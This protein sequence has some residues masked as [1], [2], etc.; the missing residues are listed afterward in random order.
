MI[1]SEEEMSNDGD[2]PDNFSESSHDDSVSL[3]VSMTS[4]VPTS[5]ESDYSIRGLYPREQPSNEFSSID[6]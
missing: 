4:N 1:D 5:Y 2:E 3:S 6:L